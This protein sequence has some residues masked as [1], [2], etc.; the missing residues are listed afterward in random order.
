MNTC[1]N[2]GCVPE[3]DQWS[4]ETLCIDCQNDGEENDDIRTD[5]KRNN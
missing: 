5:N 1:N 4:S 3:P 2:C